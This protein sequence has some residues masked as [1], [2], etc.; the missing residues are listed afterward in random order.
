MLQR[1]LLPLLFAATGLLPAHATAE[2]IHVAHAIA[3]HGEP[4]YLEGYTAF[5]YANPQAP[6]GGRI[7]QAV[8]SPGGFDSLNKWIPK[9][10]PAAGLN[11]VYD[12]LAEGSLDEPFS[13]Y[14]LLAEKME[15]P[16]DRSWIVFHLRPEAKFHDGVPVTAADVKYT[17]ELLTQKAAP[18]WKFYYR[19]VQKVEVLDARR[20]KFSFAPGTNRELALIVGQMPVMPKHWWEKRDF[21]AASLEPPLGSGPYRVQQVDPGRRIVYERVADYWGRDLGINR[22]RYNFDEIAIDYY[23]DDTVALEALKAGEY[24]IRV[25]SSAK[26]WATAYEVAAVEQKLLRRAA[27]PTRIPAGMQGWVFNTRRDIF[28]DRRVRQALAHAFDFEWT[29]RN[30]M[31]GAYTRTDSYFENSELASSGIPAGA[32]LA[33]LEPLRAQLPP[34]LFNRPYTLPVTDG[35]GNA[36]NNLNEAT[37]LLAEAGWNVRGGKLV[38][39]KTGQPMSFEILLDNPLFEPHTQALVQNLKKL[40]IDARIRSLTDTQQYVERLRKF[41]FDLI[42]DSMGQSNSPGNEQRDYWTSAAAATGD[43]ANLAGVRDPAVDVLVEKVIAADSRAALVTATH[44]LD[45]ALLWGWYTIPQWH[46]NS[47]RVV[48]WDRFGH[49]EVLPD[50]GISIEHWWYDAERA[51][52]LDERRGTSPAKKEADGTDSRTGLLVGGLLLAIAIGA[53]LFKRRRQT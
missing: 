8:V 4:K 19:D 34:E 21:T 53:A 29:N 7:R 27:L 30:L 45:R 32:E 24:D 38:N 12:T 42:I 52:A 44:A 39:A 16:E 15:W 20:V 28:A 23:R 13:E 11:Y 2:K 47:R 14:G 25:E 1:A 26:N 10:V 37:R 51:A 50:T 3:M 33:L 22:G 41:D 17:F 46:Q 18:F 36:R 9:S 5:G 48:W 31:Y 35:S 43:S 6:K 49:P 40:G